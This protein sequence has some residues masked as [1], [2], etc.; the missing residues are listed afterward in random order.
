MTPQARQRFA[1]NVRPTSDQSAR[2]DDPG[3]EGG[4]A[5]DDP[6]RR[7]LGERCLHGLRLDVGAAGA[8][9]LLLQQPP[10]DRADDGYGDDPHGDGPRRA[11]R[12]DERAS[13]C[14]RRS[15]SGWAIRSAAGKATRWS[16]TRRTSPTR[17]GS[18][19]PPQNLHVVE[20]FTRVDAKT[21]HV[22]VHDRGSRHLD[23]AVDRR[24]HV[25]GDRRAHATNTRATK[26]T[27]RWATSCAARG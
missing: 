21:L 12:P 17:R 26:A 14:R 4:G 3:F 20:R 6:E 7:P 9:E 2:E 8:A 16:S 18:A 27:T 10:S 1:R 19:A 22:P 25:A 13:T 23:E 5:Y 24:V 15:A 11:H